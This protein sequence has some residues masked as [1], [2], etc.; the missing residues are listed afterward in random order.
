MDLI[1]QS[2]GLDRPDL[3]K[4]LRLMQD[5]DLIMAETVATLSENGLDPEEVRSV[6]LDQLIAEQVLDTDPGTHPD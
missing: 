4:K 3:F 6:I 2:M 5:A 1:G